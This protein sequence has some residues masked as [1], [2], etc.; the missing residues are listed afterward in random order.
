MLGLDA[1]MITVS[2]AVLLLAGFVKGIVGLALPIITVGLL[3][4]FLP[5]PIVL[6]IVILPIVF[7]NLWQAISTGHV[8]V[9]VRRFWLVII[10]LMTTLWFSAKLVVALD[11]NTLYGIV[12]AAIVL[13]SVSSAIP[14]VPALPPRLEKWVG[15]LA[16]ALGGFLGG[17]SA[18]W[19]PPVMIFY[20]MLK[21]PKDDFI[22]ATALSWF[23]ASIPMALAHTRTGVLTFETAKLS[24]AACVPVLVG[25]WLG[26]RVR[27]RIDQ[28]MFRKLLLLTTFLIGL[29]LIR[30]AVF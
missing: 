6:A 5:V 13:F 11:A 16:G 1:S 19:A 25:L 17:V 20:V 3:S 4:S 22:R 18:I 14:S 8:F 21:L 7:A 23:C 2:T 15:P 26:E 29:N 9:A 27:N 24:L 10:C 28:E 30:R 12:G